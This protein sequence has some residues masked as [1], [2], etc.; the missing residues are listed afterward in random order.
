[1]IGGA[2]LHRWTLGATAKQEQLDDR[3]VEFPSLNGDRTGL[4]NR[5]LYAVTGDAIVKYDTVTGS[6]RVE[7][8]GGPA[9]E[10]V[11][12]PTEGARAED[13]G[14]LMSIVAT[15]DGSELRVLDAGSLERVA[16]VRLPRRVPAGFHGNWFGDEG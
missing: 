6:S 12:V 16:A 9:G 1:M 7:E 5:Y 10:A 8:T 14:W 11:F 15:E 4:A 3:E 13:D 2:T